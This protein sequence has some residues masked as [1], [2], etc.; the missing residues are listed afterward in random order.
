MLIVSAVEQVS[1]LPV[2]SR[3]HAACGEVGCFPQIEMHLEA[4]GDVM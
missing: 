3:A 1:I 4:G 2:R